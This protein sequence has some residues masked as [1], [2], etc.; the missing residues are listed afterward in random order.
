M[1]VTDIVSEASLGNYLNKASMSRG[2]AQMGAMFGSSPEERAKELSTFNKRDKGITRAKSRIEKARK[3][4]Q[5]T[6]LADLVARLPELKAD[7]EKMKAQYKALGGRN[8]QYADREQN[9]T[10]SERK[11]RDME[12]TLNNLWRQIQ[13]AEKAQSQQG[14][15]EGSIADKIKGAAKSVKRAVQGWDKN[16]IGPGGEKLGDPRD[17]VKRAKSASDD[18]V[19]R[20]AKD[21]ELGFP[22]GGDSSASPHSPRGLQKRVLD[23][24][25]KKRGLGE[26][27]VTE[28]GGISKGKETKFHSK[29]DTL[30]HDTFG[31][32]SDEVEEDW[33]KVNKKDKTDGMSSKAVKAYR[34]ENPGSKL[35]TAVTTKPSKLKKG[36]KSAKRRKSFCARMSGMKKAHAGAKTKR[37]P[38]SPI[39]KALRRWNC[40]SIEDMRNLIEYAEKVINEEKVRLDPKCWSGKKIGDPKTKIKG[41]VR[42]NNCV[43]AESVNEG[44]M[45]EVDYIVQALA[46]GEMDPYTVMNTPQSDT[47]EY[48]ARLLHDEYE[49]VSRNHRLHPDDDFEQILDIAV[50]NLVRDFGAV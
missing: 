13:A 2:K 12:G 27:G 49:E 48:V 15:T 45:A 6:Q 16:A 10:D 33:Q 22:F 24:E 38:D 14:V 39:N 29:L 21:K 9:L 8:W 44:K 19:Q 36:S 43:P 23:R 30:V 7:Y 40:E 20:L 11:A 17:I 1:K 25:M 35:K 4:T 37:D 28:A 41:G 34:R 42:V 18:S 3:E 5:A 26:Q 46:S 47:E 32:R 50:D 31:K